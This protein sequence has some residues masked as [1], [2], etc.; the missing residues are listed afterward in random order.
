MGTLPPCLL[1]NAGI[2]FAKS[3]IFYEHINFVRRKASVKFFEERTHYL[4][5]IILRDGIMMEPSK[6]EA[7]MNWPPPTNLKEIQVFLGLAEF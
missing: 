1:M 2:I 3:L 5:N 7:I 6:I 4:G